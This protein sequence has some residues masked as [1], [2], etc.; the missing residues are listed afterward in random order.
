M[1]VQGLF[2][3]N[4]GVWMKQGCLVVRNR[5]LLLIYINNLRT[6]GSKRKGKEI[7]VEKAATVEEK[8]IDV[9]Q[10]DDFVDVERNNSG[11]WS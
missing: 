10:D 11:K 6:L 4:R 5:W 8:S 7:A 9:E 2:E 3:R 1:L